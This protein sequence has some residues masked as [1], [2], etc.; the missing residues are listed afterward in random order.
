[1]IN[2]VPL[3]M[4][5]NVVGVVNCCKPRDVSHFPVEVRHLHLDLEDNQ[6]E[7]IGSVFEECVGFI[8]SVVGDEGG[9]GEEGKEGGEGGQEEGKGPEPPPSVLVH[10]NA[11]MSRSVS[12][13]MAYLIH[14]HGMPLIQAFEVLKSTRHQASPNAG[15][16]EQLTEWEIKCSGGKGTLDLERYRMDRFA[17][18]EDVR[19]K[20]GGGEFKQDP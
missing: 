4:E 13:C 7:Y 2:N 20:E 12:I 8:T 16:M 15:F 19:I 3:L 6:E 17:S 10:C 11:G 1:M 14:S 5:L 9:R 18:V